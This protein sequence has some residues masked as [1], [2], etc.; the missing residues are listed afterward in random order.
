MDHLFNSAT[1]IYGENLLGVILTGM[2]KDG[3]DGMVKIK[4]KGG[5]NIVQNKETCTVYGMPGSAVAKGVVD[6]ILSLE[7]ISQAING[8]VR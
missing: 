8:M 4:E 7:D 2:G 5:Y 1:E 6:Q 3:A